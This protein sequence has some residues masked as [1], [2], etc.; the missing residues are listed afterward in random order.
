MILITHNNKK[1]IA[2][3]SDLKKNIDFNRNIPI[4]HVLKNIASAYPSELIIWHEEGIENVLNI[5]A[6]SSLFHHDKTILS[7]SPS[8]NNFL[9]EV[10]GFVDLSIF[11]KINKEVRYPTWQM[12]ALVGGMSSTV[13]NALASEIS[14]D[15]DFEYFLNSFAKLAMPLG[16]FCY[17]EPKL[18]TEK[19]TIKRESASIYTLFKFV[20]QHYK[21]SWVFL[22]L[23][24]LI[25]YRK[26]L[27]VNSFFTESYFF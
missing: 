7:Y 21:I 16:L 4:A 3:K 17:S 20:K 8:Q 5:D 12:S 26:Q 14:F 22:L 18:L 27:A 19:I 1:V 15:N 24:N 13:I 9:N 25:I 6:I 23:L 10:I 2:V 11:I